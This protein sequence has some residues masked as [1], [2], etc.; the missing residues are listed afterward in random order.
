MTLNPHPV[1]KLE[2][3]TGWSRDGS[4]NAQQFSSHEHYR[5][6]L[7]VSAGVIDSLCTGR[8]RRKRPTA[9][10]VNINNAPSWSGH[11][12]WWMHTLVTCTIMSCFA[13]YVRSDFCYPTE[14][15]CGFFMAWRRLAVINYLLSDSYHNFDLFRLYQ[16]RLYCSVVGRHLGIAYYNLMTFIRGIIKRR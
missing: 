5:L 12:E 11:D 2:A 15:C 7:S 14:D 1:G 3:I 9:V 6:P 4:I 16:L 10:F 13:Y 8:N